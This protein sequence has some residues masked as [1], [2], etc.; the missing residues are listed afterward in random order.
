[1]RTYSSLVNGATVDIKFRQG[2]NSK[3]LNLPVTSGDLAVRVSDH[4]GNSMSAEFYD[5]IDIQCSATRIPP[6]FPISGEADIVAL[7]N[8]PTAWVGQVLAT[9]QKP[10]KWLSQMSG[11]N[12]KFQIDTNDN[13]APLLSGHFEAPLPGLYY[14]T[15][16]MISSEAST[17]LDY[18]KS[19]W[20]M[21]EPKTD[22]QVNTKVD[23][24]SY[25]KSP[26]LS[27]AW[28]KT[29]NTAVAENLLLN[30][31]ENSIRITPSDLATAQIDS[32]DS[33]S[34]VIHSRQKGSGT[35]SFDV[36]TEY[37]DRWTLNYDV[38]VN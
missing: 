3:D 25:L 17:Q 20:I 27:D 28:S 23:Q 14:V 29:S 37:G 18:S 24:D 19:F 26:F 11:R 10:E 15:L 33:Q 16:N 13:E 31:E 22:F 35:L 38:V 34:I 6:W 9:Y 12:I 36:T 30:I 32:S 1:M 8:N 2:N 7:M 21:Y 5:S 4:S